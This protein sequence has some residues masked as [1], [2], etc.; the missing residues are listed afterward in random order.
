MLNQLVRYPPGGFV[1][2]Y[3]HKCKTLMVKCM[4]N[5]LVRYLQGGQMCHYVCN[6]E[7]D[8]DCQTIHRIYICLRKY[9]RHLDQF[10]LSLSNRFPVVKEK[11]VWIQK[12]W[13]LLLQCALQEESKQ[14]ADL[15]K[16]LERVQIELNQSNEE[17]QKYQVQIKILMEENN[18][19]RDFTGKS[20]SE[21]ESM[22]NRAIALE[23][24]KMV[25]GFIF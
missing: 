14:K 17:K 13:V 9:S 19:F 1:C 22:T 2:Y 8:Y 18:R 6:C 20:E 10:H 12:N 21:L 11:L 25:V 3:M 4:P 23:V 16:E 7:T 24:H 5:Q 15:N